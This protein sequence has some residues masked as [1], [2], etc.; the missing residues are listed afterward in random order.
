MFPA[1][2]A[3]EALSAYDA[4]NACKEYEAVP[5]KDPVNPFVEIVE[6]V[7]VKLPVIT[8]LPVYGNDEAF[9]T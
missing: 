3:K 1:V 2:G 5:N 9:A 4:L 7:I 6:P 8:A